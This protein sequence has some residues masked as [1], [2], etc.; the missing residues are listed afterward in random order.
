MKKYLLLCFLGYSI[1]SIAQ[2]NKITFDYDAAG[3]QIKREL[4][5]NCITNKS[6]KSEKEILTEDYI[7]TDISDQISYYPNP[8]REELYLKWELAQEKTVTNI[9]VYSIG[10]QLVHSFQNTQ[11]N[12]LQTISFINLP[13]GIYLLQMRFSDGMEKTL[14]IIKK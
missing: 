12:N 14:K 4:C 3:N 6:Y 1:V 8:V 5:I 9:F 2:S 11:T 7:K 10:G 13:E